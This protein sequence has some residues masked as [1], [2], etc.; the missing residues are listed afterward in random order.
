M[1]RKSSEHERQGTA[2][3]SGRPRRDGSRSLFRRPNPDEASI[4]HE[5]RKERHARFLEMKRYPEQ[6]GEH[7]TFKA[8]WESIREAIRRFQ[9]A[10]GLELDD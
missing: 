8:Q 3:Q 5:F 10:H 4:I 9:R 7:K 2:F 6:S 1:K